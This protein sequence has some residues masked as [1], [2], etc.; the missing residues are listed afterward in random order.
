MILRLFGVCRGAYHVVP[1]ARVAWGTVTGGGRVV[2]AG[3]GLAGLRTAAELRER[4][5]DGQITLIGAETRPPYDRPPLSKKVL[6]DGID[7]SLQADFGALEVD[8]RP[9]EAATGMDAETLATNRDKYPYDH[10]ILAT[11]ALPVAL[12]GPG[13]QRFL[14][15]YDD[16]LA[17]RALFRPGLRL[18][19]AG[20]GWIGAELATAAAARGCEV[21]VVE[22]GPAP[23]AS[24]VGAPVGAQT[25]RWY[26]AAGVRLRT[27]AAV[28]SVQPGGLALAGGEWIAADEIVTAVGVRP[29]TGW[30]EGSGIWLENGVAVDAGLRAS[31][32]GVYAVGDCAAFES[33]RFG[34]RLRFEHWDV[35]LHAPEVVA[36]NMLGGDEA[37]DPVP[38]FWSEQFGRM[39]QYAGYH[40]DAERLVWRGDPAGPAWAACWLA[41]GR[42]VA[43]LTV[44][45]PRDL[46][47][48]R[49]VIASASPVDVGRLTDPAVPVKDAIYL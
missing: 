4:G 5:F 9:G 32:P 10:L 13:P 37:Y 2:V 48:G 26:A 44:D 42:L 46:L 49:R 21:T 12:P 3:A 27:G 24:A 39:L 34:R 28:E 1:L 30:L 29:A 22:A 20:A 17:L 31:L 14:R 43:I 6:T 33:R 11:G 25:S 36:A 19:V 41:V 38:Y 35:A 45:R 8:F 15:S 40:G 47:Q 18:T 7:P 23:L 16:A